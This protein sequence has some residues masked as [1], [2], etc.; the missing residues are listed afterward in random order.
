R[1]GGRTRLYYSPEAIASLGVPGVFRD[2]ADAATFRDLARAYF[3]TGSIVANLPYFMAE[4]MEPAAQL[5][6][7]HIDCIRPTLK[8]FL[9][10]APVA[11]AQAPMRYVPRRP[12]LDLERHRLFYRICRSGL[13]VSYYDTTDCVAFDRESIPLTL[14]ENSFLVFDNQG[15]H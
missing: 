14:S 13:G 5:E 4:V 11:I 2:L 6:P 8:V 1:P 9:A 12:R 3:D 7:W 10:L 15:P